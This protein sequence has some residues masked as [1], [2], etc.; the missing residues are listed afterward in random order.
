M[1][2]SLAF[3]LLA[4]L[5]L[6]SQ[7]LTKQQRIDISH[8]M[9]VE[10]ADLENKAC[11]DPKYVQTCKDI[12]N[13]FPNQKPEQLSDWQKTEIKKKLRAFKATLAK[14]PKYKDQLARIRQYHQQLRLDF[15]DK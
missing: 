1:K 10:A 7:E 6:H 13:A 5:S 14:D 11:A 15:E 8:K 9:A 3:L 2:F 12:Y 4:S